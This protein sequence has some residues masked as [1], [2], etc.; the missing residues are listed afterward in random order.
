M[1]IGVA[2]AVAL[3]GTAVSAGVG[4]YTA[5]QQA[6]QSKAGRN[7]ALASEERARQDVAPWRD[8]GVSA[9]GVA[10]DLSGANGVEAAQKAMAGFQ[11][12]PGYGYAVQQGLRAVDAGA[13]ARGM[14]RSGATL[15]AEQTLGNN[16]ANQQFDTYY[17]RLLGLS[18]M[19]ASAASGQAQ[20]ANN[21]AQTQASSATQQAG[22]TG[23]MGNTI[24]QGIGNAYN[25]YQNNS[26][27]GGQKNALL[28][29]GGTTA[30]GYPAPGASG[31][32]AWK[33]SG[34]GSQA[35][36]GYGPG[37]GLLY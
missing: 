20:T 16:L 19:G 10:G 22:I 7:A 8:Q 14:L 35:D 15:K 29:A 31:S 24:Q 27:Y 12:S 17:N 3:A 18:Q 9:L 4:L 30:A 23:S 21:M 36:I 34:F 26:I 5:S 33:D 1:P 25:A 13:A 11:E 2:G 6:S 37:V 28:G 32:S